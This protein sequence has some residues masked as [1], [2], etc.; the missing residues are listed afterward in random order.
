MPEEDFRSERVIH[1]LSFHKRDFCSKNILILIDK[2]PFLCY[3]YSCPFQKE[4]PMSSKFSKPFTD[5]DWFPTDL[6][7]EQVDSIVGLYQP[8]L[9]SL[10]N[11]IRDRYQD[12]YRNRKFWCLLNAFLKRQTDD[13]ILKSWIYVEGYHIIFRNPLMYQGSEVDISLK[14][15]FKLQTGLLKLTHI[16]FGEEIRDTSELYTCL[17]DYLSRCKDEKYRVYDLRKGSFENSPLV[18]DEIIIDDN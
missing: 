18:T 11:D 13:E 6:S 15:D 12:R 2:I 17:L 1:P 8:I 10:L 16:S 9:K 7:P 4:R 5:I 14:W 3:K